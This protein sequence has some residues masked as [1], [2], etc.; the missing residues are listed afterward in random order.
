MLGL[1]ARR[2]THFVRYAHSVQ[3]TATSQSRCA[4]KARGREPCASRRLAK[5]RR[6]LPGHGFAGDAPSVRPKKQRMSAVAGGTDPLHEDNRRGPS[7]RAVSR[8]TRAM[9]G[10]GVPGAACR[11][12]LR[13]VLRRRAAQ[14]PGL[15]HRPQ[16]D[17]PSAACSSSEHRQRPPVD[18]GHARASSALEPRAASSAGH[19]SL[20]ARGAVVGPRTAPAC[21]SPRETLNACKADRFAGRAAAY[22]GAALLRER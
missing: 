8:R 22:P 20:V 1:A 15:A 17:G 4:P 2:R 11:C 13:P 7:R 19:P 9:H 10:A 3:T 18:A 6:R 16:G 21:G 14:A 5:A 12:R